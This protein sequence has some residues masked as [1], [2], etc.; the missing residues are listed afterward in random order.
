VRALTR[1][2]TPENE[3]TV[4]MWAEHANASHLEKL[5]RLYRRYGDEAAVRAQY[6]QR[7]CSYYT[8]E[9]GSLV[10]RAQL[11]AELGAIVLKALEAARRS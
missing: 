11:P 7:E 5:A 1:V 8:D 3:D 6:R 9:D 2:A 4:L 10:I